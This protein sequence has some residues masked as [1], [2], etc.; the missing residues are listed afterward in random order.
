MKVDGQCLSPLVD[1]GSSKLFFVE[2][3]YLEST[4]SPKSCNDFVF[5]CYECDAHISD[6]EVSE[7]EHCDNTCAHV[8]RYRGVLEMGG[9]LVHDVEFGLLV[10]Y[11]PKGYMPHASLGL[12]PQFDAGSITLLGQLMDKGA[13]DNRAFSIY[14]KPDN[15]SEGELIIGGEDSS[16]Y[17]EPV[18]AV[19]LFDVGDA[20]AVR[21]ASL[22]VGEE[23][24]LESVP[25]DIDS[26]T[27][28]FWLPFG[29]HLSLWKALEKSAS[30]R[31]GRQIKFNYNDGLL[32]LSR[33]SDRVYLPPL[34][35]HVRDKFGV[36]SLIVI[37]SD[38]YVQSSSSPEGGTCILLGRMDPVDDLYTRPT[39]GLNLLREYYLHFQYDERE[40]RFAR[41]LK[42][43]D[44]TSQPLK[45][46]SREQ[47]NYNKPTK[48]MEPDSSSSTLFDRSIK[49]VP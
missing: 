27:S 14:F 4:M 17:K 39:I 6:A 13:I 19:P 2:K 20:W 34:E 23:T 33:C 1:T 24:I 28:Y 37:S 42:D 9:Q 35:V 11:E 16:K 5:G 7:I 46:S 18:I 22:V 26:G 47:G 29:L 3:E 25:M 15:Y 30:L 43:S 44:T 12:A 38:F 8:V 10:N 49:L 41:M 31:A 48:S 21:V 32:A 36:V 40:I 45:A